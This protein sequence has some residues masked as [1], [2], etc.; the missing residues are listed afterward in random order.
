MMIYQKNSNMRKWMN[1]FNMLPADQSATNLK[2]LK[3]ISETW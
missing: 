3:F 1:I 2:A